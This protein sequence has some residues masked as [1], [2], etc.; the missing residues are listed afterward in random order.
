MANL[1]DFK[2]SQIVRAC[3]V[4]ASV[5]KTAQMFDVSRGTVSKVRMTAFQKEGKTFTTKHKSG[6]KS[7]LSEKDRRTLNRIVRKDRRITA[8]KITTELNEHLQ[9]PVSTKIQPKEAFD[10]DCLQPTV[11]HDGGS[12]MIWGAI[13]WKSTGLMISLHGK[14]NSRDYLQILS[15][16][17]YSMVQALFPDGNAIFQDDNAPIHTARIVKEWHEEHCNEAD[18]FEWPAQSP[19]LNIIEH[20]SISTPSF[21]KELEGIL[22]EEWFAI[23]LRT[24]HKLYESIPRRIEAVIASKGKCTP[25]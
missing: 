3:M 24:I 8:L 25:Y 23:P 1:S 14:I 4:G 10:S 22:T 11:K 7:K 20:I 2:R 5:T 21:L 16:Q 9:N 18:H 17:V 19:D 13:F 12:V 6:R 15:D